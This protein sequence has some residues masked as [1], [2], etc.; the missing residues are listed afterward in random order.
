MPAIGF[1]C[2]NDM[3]YAYWNSAV[4]KCGQCPNQCMA[5][6]ALKAAA[7]QRPWTGKPSVTQ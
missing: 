5:K 7:R 6:P 2:P 4:D 1:K 3:G